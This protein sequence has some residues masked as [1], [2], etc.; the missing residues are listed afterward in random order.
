M[1]CGRV[2]ARQRKKSGAVAL[3]EL[4]IEFSDARPHR[5]NSSCEGGFVDGI[6]GGI[7][8]ERSFDIF[9][10]VPSPSRRREYIR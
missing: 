8:N 4:L 9:R 10:L 6:R 5:L 2:V 7:L 3:L 1:E